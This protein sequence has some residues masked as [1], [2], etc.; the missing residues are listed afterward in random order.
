M[1]LWDLGILI[2]NR[3]YQAGRPWNE[4]T[5]DLAWPKTLAGD[6]LSGR[7]SPFLD[8]CEANTICV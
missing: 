1:D 7:F 2:A 3:A 4:A 8:L 6:L 5:L